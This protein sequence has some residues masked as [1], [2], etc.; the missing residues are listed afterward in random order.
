M[1]AAIE[2]LIKRVEL[3]MAYARGAVSAA[4]SPSVPAAWPVPPPT[5]IA[6]ALDDLAGGGG[7]RASWLTANWYVKPVTG[8]DTNDGLTAATAVKTIMGGIVAKWGTRAPILAQDTVIHLL[9]SETVGQEHVVLSQVMVGGTAFA[10]LG[11]PTLVRTF[12]LGVV[13]PKHVST[14]QLLQAAGFGGA[15]LAVGQLV[16]NNATGSSSFIETLA[17]PVA[18][19]AQP[20]VNQS[21]PA[22]ASLFPTPVE[23][24]TWATGQSVSVYN[25]PML[26]LQ[27]V[28]PRGG[29]NTP[30]DTRGLTWIQGIF[31]PD[32]SGVAGQS[33]FAPQSEDQTIIFRDCRIGPFGV[34]GPGPEGVDSV[35]WINCAMDG[36]VNL[37]YAGLFGG[38]AHVFGVNMT[39]FASIDGDAIVRATGGGSV[40]TLFGTDN[41]IG[42]CFA[43]IGGC[44]ALTG[45]TVSLGAGIGA[46]AFYGPP[47]WPLSV[48]KGSE[49]YNSTGGSW[50]L[51]VYQAGYAIDGS[52]NGTGYAAGV[53]TDGIAI[54]GANLDAHGGLQNPRTGSRFAPG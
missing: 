8:N 39:G 43:D 51:C 18:T 40:L 26:N 15:G 10:M 41:F 35:Q 52:G 54:T 20:L 29:D 38:Y 3:A 7:P 33:V 36:G 37:S 12:N 25:L 45:A 2:R 11:T 23:D 50:T 17:G 31:V 46:A 47:G 14:G 28:A 4:F 48:E 22:D 32:P 16:V 9:E 5:T 34:S 27:F 13:T 6:A 1:S 30:T 42:A 53:W 21:F 24:D 49:F 44:S 19:L